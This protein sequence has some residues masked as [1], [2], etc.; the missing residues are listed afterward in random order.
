MR[1]S[2]MFSL[3]V[4][5]V[6][7][8]MLVLGV[9]IALGATTFSDVPSTHPFYTDITRLADLEI[10]GGFPDGTYKPDDPVTRQQFAK[11]I[12][13]ATDRHTDAIDNEQNPTFSDVMPGMGVPYPFD[14]VEEAAEAGF[15]MGDQGK[16]NPANNITR[17]QLALVVV[18]AGGAG[19]ADPPVGYQTGFTDV[20]AYAAAEVAKAKFNGILNGKTATTFDPYANATRGQVAKMVSRL[21]DTMALGR[22]IGTTAEPTA[23]FQAIADRLNAVLALG[24]NTTNPDVV[25]KA[26]FDANPANDPFV[27]DTREPADFAKGHIPG[28]VNIPLLDLPQA[29]LDADSRIPMAQEVVIASYWGDDGDMAN[30]LVNLYRIADPAAQKAALDAKTATPYPKSTVIFQGMTAWSFERDL[31]PTGTRFEDALAA[32]VIV[33]KPL[34]AGTVTGV[35][36][37]AYPAFSA[38]GTD[39]VVTKALLR[40]KDYFSGFTTQFGTQVYP[41][42]LAQNLEDGNAANDPQLVS[43]RA[44]NH[45]ALGHIPGAINIPYQKV[46][47]VANFTKFVDPSHPI[48][49]YCYTGHTGGIATMALGILGYD[50]RN[51][52]YGVNG[53]NQGA[54]G[55]GQLKSFD[56]MK[57]WDFPVND[58]GADDLTSLADYVAPSGCESCHT[59]L[60]GIFYDREVANPVAAGEAPPSEGEG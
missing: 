27:L 39:A 20:P 53:W 32:G 50:V 43:V 6:L 15:V 47:D 25:A 31:V 41:S 37:G 3:S 16:F 38:F 26:L 29:L 30:L 12:V 23:D 14:Y 56:L 48:I 22:V 46:A 2:D 57:A 52:L 36:Q 5:V 1:R 42:A 18:R 10:V 17:V 19:L 13:L 24:Y 11:I 45:Y 35:D 58:G 40:A 60:T 55:A 4:L 44:T 51:L 21:L 49:A 9:G 34:E 7:A 33:Q 8:L 28:A 59:S 54:P